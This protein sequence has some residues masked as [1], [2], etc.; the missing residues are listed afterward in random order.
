MRTQRILLALLCCALP[1]LSAE[2]PG[3]QAEEPLAR[4]GEAVELKHKTEST[5][6][7]WFAGYYR[8]GWDEIISIHDAK[9]G[10]QVRKI[11]GHGDE[12]VEMKFTP[13]GN[14]LA[15]RCLN[16]GRAGWALWDVATGKLIMRLGRGDE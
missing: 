5:D 15:T 9:T 8:D 1:P 2:P 6:G 4:A 10:K 16:S 12:V 7:R 11:V 13:D 3:K 14:T